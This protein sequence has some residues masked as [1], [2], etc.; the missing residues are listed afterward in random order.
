MQCVVVSDQAGKQKSCVSFVGIKAP[1]RRVSSE[2]VC[3]GGPTGRWRPG[4]GLSCARRC[5]G[6]LDVPQTLDYDRGVD[7]EGPLASPL[8]AG[9]AE[10][11]FCV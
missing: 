4:P 8:P 1:R 11:Y 10:G 9:Q 2:V 3:T 6:G 7:Q 5:S